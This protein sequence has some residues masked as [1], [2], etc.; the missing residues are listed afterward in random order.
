MTQTNLYKDKVVAELSFMQ[1]WVKWG[2]ITLYVWA[3]IQ[4]VQG[5]HN[6]CFP[7]QDGHFRPFMSDA[8][9]EH[10]RDTTQVYMKL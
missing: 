1:V 8:I 2:P 6:C 5:L 9:E 10:H 3:I 4:Y 7:P